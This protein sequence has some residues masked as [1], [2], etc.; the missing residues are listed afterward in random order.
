MFL[1]V[2]PRMRDKPAMTLK[3]TPSYKVNLPKLRSRR[4]DRTQR[5]QAV[6]AAY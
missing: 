4:N 1:I 2:G 5:A 3:I 6:L